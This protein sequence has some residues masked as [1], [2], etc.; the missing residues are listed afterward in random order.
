MTESTNPSREEV[1]ADLLK[2]MFATVEDEIGK[3]TPKVLREGESL[4]I[5]IRGTHT[6]ERPN[7]DGSF[8]VPK[9]PRR[10]ER[11][12]EESDWEAIERST[13]GKPTK[14]VVNLFRRLGNGNVTSSMMKN[15]WNGTIV[16]EYRINPKFRRLNMPYRICKADR[17]RRGGAA[18][19]KWKLVKI[20]SPE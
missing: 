10:I 19:R 9:I 1:V 16:S 20:S 14:R 8:M 18:R 5:I 7:V 12:L 17:G 11:E 6:E 4:T 13:L 15:A 3:W 2:G